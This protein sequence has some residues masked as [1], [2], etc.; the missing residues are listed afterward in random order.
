MFR[1]G[2]K[3]KTN[4]EITQTSD[5]WQLV[6]QIQFKNYFVLVHLNADDLIL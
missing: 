3:V 5:K 2:A 4:V 1:S 6:L